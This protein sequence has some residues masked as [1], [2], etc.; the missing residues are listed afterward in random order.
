MANTGRYGNQGGYSG[1]GSGRPQF[2]DM[3]VGDYANGMP[4]IRLGEMFKSLLR[5][6]IWLVPFAVIGAAIAFFA[7][8]SFKRTYKGEGRILVQIGNEYVFDPASGQSAPGLMM[9]PDV[10]TLNETAIM[11]N[12]EVVQTVI[13]QMKD[14]FGEQ[15]F[16]PDA[17]DKINAAID[18]RDPQ[19]VAI[20]NVD[21]HQAVNKAFEVSPQPK[22]SIV[23]LAYKHEDGDIAVATLNAFIQA[24]LDNRRKIFVEGTAGD[25]SERLKATEEQIT[26]NAQEIQTF[27]AR[28]RIAD[29]DSE[30]TGASARAETIRSELNGLRAQLSETEA[31]LASVETQLR[32]TSPKIDLYVDDR[33]AQRV[34]QAE[35]ELKTLLSRYLPGSDPVRAKQAEIN[36]LK[37][38]Q[39][40]NSGAAIGGRR[41]GP[42]TVYQ[43]LMTRRNLLQSTADSYR[44][45]EFALQKQLNAADGKVRRLQKLAPEYQA[46]LREKATLDMRH[47]SYTQKEQ[48][49]LINNRQVDSSSE[50]V[51]VIS[52]ATLPRK[53]RNMRMIMFAL[54]TLGIWATLGMIALLKVFLDPRLY[55]TP[56]QFGHAKRGGYDGYEDYG[57]APP[58]ETYHATPD[59]YVPEPVSAP[60]ME[61]AASI[62]AEP[63]PS[64]AFVPA[65]FE[66]TPPGNAAAPYDLAQETQS[67]A[68]PY[69]PYEGNNHPQAYDLNQNPYGVA[70]PYTPGSDPGMPV[71]GTVPSSEQG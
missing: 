55:S 1:S 10:I 60:P 37:A 44:E 39:A 57:Y 59:N 21:L 53:G 48:E 43:A 63:D 7:T 70:T 34:A 13:N 25:V 24:Y 66:A 18:S 16:A 15:R 62:P 45:K 20:A 3:T 56:T 8:S 30:R 11:K 19:A 50:N 68:S 67:V 42:N 17:Y 26:L 31:A 33:A 14:K 47:G 40:S 22:S 49:A 5:Q 71:L 51:K 58:R 38:L 27:L 36:Q 41:V 46:L 32:Q 65:P 29:F 6:F 23:N 52:W 61:R 35:L 28:N 64:P 54:V 9:T 4:S 12:H 69:T 2:G